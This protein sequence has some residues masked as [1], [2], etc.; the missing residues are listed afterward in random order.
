MVANVEMT[1]RVEQTES[2]V[3]GGDS[4]PNAQDRGWSWYIRLTPAR[5]TSRIVLLNIAGLI[6]LVSGILYFN[7]FRQ[8]LID[9][10]VQSLLT[11]GQI[12]AAAIASAASIDTDSIVVDPD[13]LLETQP[14]RASTPEEDLNELD[15]P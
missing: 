3:P 4:S 2:A 14:N 5:L 6:I 1:E 7:Q 10:R 15:F 13:R 8:G 11:Q 9:A 12:M